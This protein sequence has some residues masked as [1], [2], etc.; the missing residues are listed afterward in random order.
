MNG[1]MQIVGLD[2]VF[3]PGCHCAFTDMMYWRGRIWL[4]FREAVNHSIHLSSNIVV[5]C[6]ADHGMHFQEMGRISLRGIDVR[7]PHFYIINDYLHITIAAW[8]GPKSNDH[9]QSWIARSDNGRD[10]E[11]QDL[12]DNL[13]H[14]T[15]WRPR[16]ADDGSWYAAAYD[17]DTKENV[18]KVTLMKTVD[19][20]HWQ[21]V[22]IIHDD[23]FPN[24]TELCFLDDG[25]LLA[26]VRREESEGCCP[27]IA[28]A[29]PP[30]REWK[31]KDCSRF[32]QGPLLEKLDDGTLLVV[33]RSPL[34]LNGD[35]HG[36]FVTRLHTL[37]VETGDLTPGLALESGNDTS[38]ASLIRLPDSAV[39]VRNG[40]ANALLSY[41]SGHGY[42]NGAYCD[43]DQSQRCAIYVA[44]LRI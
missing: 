33:G 26:L 21:D 18:G 39:S 16:R 19:G 34:D 2:P 27:L 24:E 8:E 14:R 6:S 17:R 10:W 44:R 37:D 28:I 23:E 42:D 15:L 1:S 22:S 4:T 3:D 31:K 36:P 5:L 11:V 32:L 43:G 25:R 35:N 30:Y 12:A 38:Y 7:D 40:S 13:D 41:Y 20:E 9:R 29:K